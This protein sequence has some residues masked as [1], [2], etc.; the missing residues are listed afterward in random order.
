MADVLPRND[1]C[2]GASALVCVAID[3][4][5]SMV[6][7]CPYIVKYRLLCRHGLLYLLLDRRHSI[8]DLVVVNYFESLSRSWFLSLRMCCLLNDTIWVTLKSGVES[9]YQL[10]TWATVPLPAAGMGIPYNVVGIPHM[11]HTSLEV[12]DEN[13]VPTSETVVAVGTDVVSDPVRPMS[14]TAWGHVAEYVFKYI[15]PADRATWNTWALV[16]I[17]VMRQF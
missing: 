6:L 13:C 15:E 5:T 16:L 2:P 10:A 7:W 8:T 17:E 3:W 4:S 14:M 11:V 1:T 9:Y 12:G